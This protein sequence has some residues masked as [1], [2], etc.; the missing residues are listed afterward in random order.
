MKKISQRPN[1]IVKS[2]EI[3]SKE[4]QD[5]NKGKKKLKSLKESKELWDEWVEESEKRQKYKQI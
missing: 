1:S 4:I 3:S 2:I 5:F